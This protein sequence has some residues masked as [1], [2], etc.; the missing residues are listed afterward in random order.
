MADTTASTGD[1]LFRGALDL[2]G[3]VRAGEV[4]ARDLVEA[5][6]A[7]I[8]ALNPG[9]NA[10]V[11]VFEDEA[12]AAAAASASSWKT[13]TNALSPGLRSSMRRSDASTRSWADSSPART[14]RARSSAGRR[15]RSSSMGGAGYPRAV[16]PRGGRP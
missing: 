13:S 4:S 9:L 2:A 5:S 1:L 8:D 10:F 11:D 3:L 6:L 15:R 7:R 16:G 12:L 14:A